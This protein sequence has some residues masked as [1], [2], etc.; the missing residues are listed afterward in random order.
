MIIFYVLCAIIILSMA[1]RKKKATKKVFV[2]KIGLGLPKPC[3]YVIRIKHKGRDLY[4][5]GYSKWVDAR[6]EDIRVSLR[7]C[8]MSTK[9]EVVSKEFREDAEMIEKNYHARNF[10]RRAC[11]GKSSGTPYKLTGRG[12][13]YFDNI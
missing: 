12:E 6:I 1:M 4:K 8:K 9:I 13:W 11:K 2:P 3:I 10:N 7:E 5:V